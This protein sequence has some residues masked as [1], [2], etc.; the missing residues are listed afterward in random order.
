MLTAHEERLLWLQALE[1]GT[2]EI[3]VPEA[4][5]PK[6]IKP[7]ERMLDFTSKTRG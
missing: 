7:L 4:L 1:Q 5:I 6:A 3:H 2:D